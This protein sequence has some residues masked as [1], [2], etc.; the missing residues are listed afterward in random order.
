[1]GLGGNKKKD[2]NVSRNDFLKSKKQIIAETLTLCAHEMFRS[3]P[4]H[5]FCGGNR[6][7]MDKVKILFALCFIFGFCFAV[8]IVLFFCF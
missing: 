7:L 1:M 5:E 2:K 6:P 8:V 4:A 3:T